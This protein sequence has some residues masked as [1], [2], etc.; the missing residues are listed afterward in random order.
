MGRVVPCNSEDEQQPCPCRVALCLDHAISK[1][2]DKPEPQ[3]E[4]L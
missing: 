1:R 2:H 3:C 4:Q